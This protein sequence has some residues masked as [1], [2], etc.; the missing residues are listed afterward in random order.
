MWARG[1]SLIGVKEAKGTLQS[2]R[3]DIFDVIR[4]AVSSNQKA[5][6]IYSLG[7]S[8]LP[9]FHATKDFLNVSFNHVSECEEYM[10]SLKQFKV[11]GAI[12]Y[13]VKA[14][15][16]KFRSENVRAALE[17]LAEE[18]ERAEDPLDLASDGRMQSIV[19]AIKNWTPVIKDRK[20]KKEVVE[21]WAEKV[22]DILTVEYA[23]EDADFK[24]IWILVHTDEECHGYNVWLTSHPGVE[25][26]RVEAV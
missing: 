1:S 15:G 18:F 13:Y 10:A 25:G 2:S 26:V 4:G 3:T 11:F 24:V 20:L 22:M 7:V 23:K 9:F 19:H 16:F 8:L 12:A 5:Y 17:C 6:A 14:L 21:K